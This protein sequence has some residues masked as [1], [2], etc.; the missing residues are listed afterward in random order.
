MGRLLIRRFWVRVPGGAH[1]YVLEGEYDFRVGDGEFSV[2]PGALVV[3]P[4]G[5]FHTFTTATG[6]PML[7]ACSPSGN[8]ELFVEMGRLGPAAT[9]E[10][11]SKLNDRF[12]TVSLPGDEGSPWQRM[13]AVEP[14]TELRRIRLLTVVTKRPIVGKHLRQKRD[15]PA[16]GGAHPFLSVAPQLQTRASKVWTT[17]S[18]SALRGLPGSAED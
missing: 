7:F 1:S 18:G 11:L 2:G 13:F 17:W 8:A 14:R 15:R 10:Q 3:V 12:H 16:P 4:K 5:S 6:G 9:A